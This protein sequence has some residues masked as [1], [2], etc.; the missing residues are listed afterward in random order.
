MEVPRFVAKKKKKR[1][2]KK[3][4]RE[5]KAPWKWDGR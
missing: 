4:K 3:E 2:K 1:L 5:K